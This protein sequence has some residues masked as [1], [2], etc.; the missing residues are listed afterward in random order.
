MIAVR[1]GCIVALLLMV[2]GLLGLWGTGRLHPL[3]AIDSNPTGSD[4]PSEWGLDPV[5][6]DGQAEVATY[7]AERVVYQKTRRFEA[8]LITVKEDFNTA[9]YVK[10]DGPY[11]GK[12][13]LTVLKLNVLSEIQTENYPYRYMTSLFID[14]AQP[15]RVV[16]MTTSSQEWCGTTFKE[17]VG[18]GDSPKLVFHSYFDNQGDGSYPLGLR[19]GDL[20]EDQLP[21]SLRSLPFKP[22]LTFTTHL[23]ESQITNRASAPKVLDATITVVGQEPAETGMGMIPSWNVEVKAGQLVQHYW[24]EQAYPN[25]LTRFTSSDGRQLVLKDRTRRKYW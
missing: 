3:Y 20:L 1:N 22:G 19:D 24:F 9:L 18:W 10:A 17:F 8:V 4:G 23:L 14:R 5:W 25:I 7:E 12:D 15:M 6:D 16:K 11:D 13:L 2:T 21:V